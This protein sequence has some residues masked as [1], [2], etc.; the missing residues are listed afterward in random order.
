MTRS[1]IPSSAPRF[2]HGSETS[3]LNVAVTGVWSDEV[4]AVTAS[5]RCRVTRFSHPGHRR[6]STRSQ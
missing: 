4:H 3:R 6:H 2:I 5:Y 1:T